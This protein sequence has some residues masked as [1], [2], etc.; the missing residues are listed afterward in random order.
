MI[1]NALKYSQNEELKKFLLGT[2]DKILVEASPRDI[3]SGIG[4][5]KEQNNQDVYRP[6]KWKRLNL[7]GFSL[8]N[9][10]DI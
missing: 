3:F 7:M 9:S 4:I 6:F 1:L 10:R 2:G 5:E 8:I